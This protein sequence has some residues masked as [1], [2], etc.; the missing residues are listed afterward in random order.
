MIKS[1]IFLTLMLSQGNNGPLFILLLYVLILFLL[2]IYHSARLLARRRAI[3]GEA[4]KVSVLAMHGMEKFH[5]VCRF[6]CPVLAFHRCEHM[7]HAGGAD[8]LNAPLTDQQERFLCDY[9]TGQFFPCDLDAEPWV[10]RL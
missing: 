7:R 4:T 2:L 5:G 9:Y 3:H 8:M 10:H 6:C 1:G